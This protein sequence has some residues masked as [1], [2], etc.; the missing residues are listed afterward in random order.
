[1]KWKCYTKSNTMLP[2][3]ALKRTTRRAREVVEK[4]RSVHHLLTEEGTWDLALD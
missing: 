2:E 4:E 1:M 3:T